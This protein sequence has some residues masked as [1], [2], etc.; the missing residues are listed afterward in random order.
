[1]L[2][3]YIIFPQKAINAI[4]NIENLKKSLKILFIILEKCDKI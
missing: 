1:M 3:F 2:L 4:K